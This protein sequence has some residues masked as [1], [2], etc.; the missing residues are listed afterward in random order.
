[1]SPTGDSLKTRTT[2]GSGEHAT[3]GKPRLDTGYAA[4]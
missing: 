4:N 3:N 2:A 1:M